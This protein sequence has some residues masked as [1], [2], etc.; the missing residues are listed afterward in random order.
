MKPARLGPSFSWIL[1]SSALDASGFQAGE[2]RLEF[3][4]KEILRSQ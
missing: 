4:V 2:L 1:M 3:W